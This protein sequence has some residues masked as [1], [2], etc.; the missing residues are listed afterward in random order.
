MIKELLTFDKIDLELIMT[1]ETTA[2]LDVAQSAY[3]DKHGKNLLSRA[4][5]YITVELID[6]LD[7][8]CCVTAPRA[9]KYE[10][11]TTKVKSAEDGVK[12]AG[13]QINGGWME[14][15]NDIISACFDMDALMKLGCLSGEPGRRARTAQDLGELTLH[16]LAERAMRQMPILF[17]HPHASVRVLEADF[18]MME[19]KSA[20]RDL[21]VLLQVE[22]DVYVR[23]DADASAVLEC[24]TWKD[25]PMARLFLNKVDEERDLDSAPQCV[26]IANAVNKRMQDE[27]GPGHIHQNI[28]D[29]Q[30]SKRHKAM[31]MLSIFAAQFGSGV[32]DARLPNHVAVSKDEVADSIW[33]QFRGKSERTNIS[34]KT[35][36]VDWPSRCN[37]MLKPGLQWPSPTVPTHA[38][39]VCAWSWCVSYQE[40]Q[41]Q[42]GLGYCNAWYSR[43]ATRFAA[44]SWDDQPGGAYIPLFC[45]NFGCIVLSAL[46]VLPGG[47]MP[48]RIRL[49]RLFP[50]T[51]AKCYVTPVR[52]VCK[53]ELGLV[54]EPAGPMQTL[55][56]AALSRRHPFTHWEVDQALQEFVGKDDE[57][58]K[59]A[60]NAKEQFELFVSSAFPDDVEAVQFILSLYERSLEEA[61]DHDADMEA[62]LEDLA[63][64]ND[65]NSSDLKGSL[66]DEKRKAAASARKRQRESR[67]KKA[68]AKKAKQAK[69]TA[70]AKKRPVFKMR[71]PKALAKKL[72]GDEAGGASPK[73]P[74]PPSE[75]V[76]PPVA[77]PLEPVAPA[78]PAPVPAMVSVDRGAPATAAG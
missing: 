25:Q 20:A 78:T 28:C 64:M 73:E 42:K 37:D 43:L 69:K 21:H 56:Q 27:K 40:E 63:F 19:V 29:V 70:K 49:A 59:L 65:I 35:S 53:A 39:S 50:L 67:E 23:G 18:E 76:A 75:P 51:D 4:P 2:N 62:V 68:A 10:H 15:L 46:E 66:S 48:E 60:K 31:P 47:Y 26:R 8:Y 30:R 5:G 58:I 54:Y 32:V 13:E 16:F 45:G 17:Q 9:K 1:T 34:F 55:F 22:D 24:I 38:N 14:E 74:A 6:S 61:D 33:T 11:M 52:V 41:K 77:L 12:C 44:L 57:R 36:L 3:I 71:L 7:I 72:R